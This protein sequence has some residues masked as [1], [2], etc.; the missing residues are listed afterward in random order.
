MGKC[1]AKSKKL[2]LEADRLSHERS[3]MKKRPATMAGRFFG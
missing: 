3:A 2:L 1:C